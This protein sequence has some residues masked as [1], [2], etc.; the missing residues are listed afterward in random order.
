MR[1]GE[2]FCPAP[3]AQAESSAVEA[4]EPTALDDALNGFHSQAGP[5][6][7]G[8]DWERPV[9]RTGWCSRRSGPASVVFR[10]S[11]KR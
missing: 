3:G 6:R 1:I 11:R 10:D 8:R 9:A 5:G 4:V 7:P 2:R